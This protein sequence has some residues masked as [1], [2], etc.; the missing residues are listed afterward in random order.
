M[1]KSQ[2]EPVC[3]LWREENGVRW[4]TASDTGFL[5]ISSLGEATLVD[6][7]PNLRDRQQKP[8]HTALKPELYK[9]LSQQLVKY[10]K[11]LRLLLTE[12]LPIEWQRFPFEWL[13]LEDGRNLQGR[14]LVERYVPRSASAP[15]FPMNSEVAVLNLL[16]SK[17]RT[18]FNKLGQIDQ[19]QIYSG[20]GA[21]KIFLKQ[22]NLSALSMLCLIAHGSGQPLDK[23]LPF[24]SENQLPWELPI[25]QGLPPLVLLVVCG[26]EQGN[27]VDYGKSLLK[28]GVQTVITA[29][30]APQQLPSLPFLQNF[31]E[32]WQTGKPVAEILLNAQ[33]Q[34]NSENAA[35]KLQ[36]LGRGELRIRCDMYERNDA[37]LIDAVHAGNQDALI[38]LVN[39]ITLAGFQTDGNLHNA[40]NEL[41]KALNI[42]YGDA[43]QEDLLKRLDE[44]EQQIWYLSRAWVIPLLAKFAESYDH[45]LLNKYEKAR[46][47]LDKHLGS[48]PAEIYHYWASVP[49]RQ[50]YYASAAKEVANGIRLLTPET[51]CTLGEGILGQL[52]NILIDLNFKKESQLLCDTLDRCL[53]EQYTEATKVE[54][55]CLLDRIARIYLRL[56]KTDAAIAKYKRKRQESI[57]DFKSEEQPELAGQRELAWLL[58]VTAFTK[59][60][61]A[62]KYAHEVKKIIADAT[63]DTM[64]KGNENLIYLMRAFSL[65]AWRFDNEAA[66]NLLMQSIDIIQ[67][68]L[69]GGDAG[70]PGFTITYLH[71]YKQAHPEI[72]LD[73]PALE[74]VQSALE[75]DRYWIELVALS[76][77][78][79]IEREPWLRKFQTQRLDCLQYLENLPKWLVG[80]VDFKASI[81]KQTRK[82]NKVLLGKPSI[83]ELIGTGLLPL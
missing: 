51:L 58:Y 79:G 59:H 54:R 46:A 26:N 4:W 72:S 80:T 65:W 16:P 12:D 74:E 33:A 62:N 8:L 63:S 13:H 66:V 36:L 52:V 69:S 37:N 27:L 6:Q 75:N 83:E 31:L 23:E 29:V 70:P 2:I 57:R 25:E 7:I 34:R 76:A 82:E 53:A 49:Y 42:A 9:V 43:K 78:L 47:I 11:G 55:H 44:I 38:M 10:P 45:T 61:D 40:V 56:G 73:L 41:R 14:L 24:V 1:N 15:K 18:T 30:G 50:G 17:E 81:E 19:V 68:R 67:E 48:L 77:L 28:L 20:T 64:G 32:E 5:A 60:K 71:L 22:K 39:R 21:V 3:W 35:Q